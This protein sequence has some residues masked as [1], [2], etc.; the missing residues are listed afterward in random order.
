MTV[1]ANEGTPS[2]TLQGTTFYFCCSGCLK[3]FERDPQR[4]LAQT[5]EPGAI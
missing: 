1:E 2:T 5:T 4:Y 3:R